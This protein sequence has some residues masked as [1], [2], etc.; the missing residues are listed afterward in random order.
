MKCFNARCSKIVDKKHKFCSR[1]CSNSF[2]NPILKSGKSLSDTTKNK[3]RNSLRKFNIHEKPCY[4]CS[5]MTA[6]RK[7]C[8]LS[9][10]SKYGNKIRPIRK[11]LSEEH[12]LKLRSIMVGRVASIETKLKHRS[13]RHSQETKRKQRIS[14]INY[15]KSVGNYYYPRIGMNETQLLDLQE[16]ID[17]CKIRRQHHIKDLGYVTDGYCP[18]TNTIYEVYEPA[19]DQQVLKDHQIIQA[20]QN[21]SLVLFFNKCSKWRRY[22]PGGKDYTNRVS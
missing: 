22:I 17:N 19:H 20:K 1:S 3:I 9:C 11:I 14:A 7:F 4:Y 13:H 2:W 10:A 18:E 8:S 21:P 5:T 6:N 15:R 12:K 16:Q